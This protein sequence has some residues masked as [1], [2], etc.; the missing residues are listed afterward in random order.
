MSKYRNSLKKEDLKKLNESDKRE[1]FI[2][3]GILSKSESTKI[4]LPSKELL[5]EIYATFYYEI[6]DCVKKEE[7]PVLKIKGELKTTIDQNER[8]ALVKKKYA[9]ASKKFHKYDLSLAYLMSSEDLSAI[10]Y[11]DFEAY[12]KDQISVETIEEYVTG[13]LST[14][15]Y[16][17][18]YPFD[19]LIKIEETKM[20]LEYLESQLDSTNTSKFKNEKVLTIPQKLILIDIIREI[21][22]DTWDEM[23]YRKRASLI[24]LLTGNSEQNIRKFISKL[25]KSSV[26]NQT[27]IDYVNALIK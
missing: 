11:E 23:D 9:K 8:I 7:Y 6:L 14:I 4:V 5:N 15:Y 20:I 26:G 3:K 25:D 10:L 22:V 17:E 19:E 1:L 24:S 16:K 2:T 21:E 13:E 27:N 18:T 12:F